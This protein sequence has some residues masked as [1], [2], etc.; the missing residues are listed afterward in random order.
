MSASMKAKDV[1]RGSRRIARSAAVF[2]CCSDFVR[3]Q[4]R[5]GAGFNGTCTI[6]T[7][8]DKARQWTWFSSMHGL[9]KEINKVKAKCRAEFGT[10]YLK[11]LNAALSMYHSMQNHADAQSVV[12]LSDGRPGDLDLNNRKEEELLTTMDQLQE[13]VLPGKLQF[14]SIGFGNND[15]VWLRKMA[16]CVSGKFHNQQARGGGFSFTQMSSTFRSISSEL[17]AMRSSAC[18]STT[19]VHKS[20]AHTSSTSAPSSKA[21]STL[22]SYNRSDAFMQ[23]LTCSV[24]P[25]SAEQKQWLCAGRGITSHVSTSPF[26][27]GSCRKAFRVSIC[28]DDVPN[29]VAETLKGLK[30]E[31]DECGFLLLVGK[32]RRFPSVTLALQF[33]SANF[34]SLLFAKTQLSAFKT[35]LRSAPRLPL[36]YSDANDATFLDCLLL[37]SEEG[38]CRF[39]SVERYLKGPYTKYNNNQGYVHPTY[40]SG[41]FKGGEGKKGGLRHTVVICG[42]RKACRCFSLHSKGNRA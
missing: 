29:E 33:Q 12:F 2:E 9:V 28:P 18:A 40:K 25:Y 41:G 39:F 13:A 31:E 16:A 32:E 22:L 14:H 3:D 15:F 35:A 26:A 20:M 10:K 17:T 19:S 7:F 23:Q 42:C 5:N 27:E 6:I 4:I 34:R 8:N 30:P 36:C 11:G 37:S 38:P 1:E 21:S 24:S